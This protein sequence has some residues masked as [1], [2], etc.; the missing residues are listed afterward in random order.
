VLDGE[1]K[2]IEEKEN[3]LGKSMQRGHRTTSSF[4]TIDRPVDD[5]IPLDAFCDMMISVQQSKDLHQKYRSNNRRYPNGVCFSPNVPLCQ[6]IKN[7]MQH[8]AWDW[9]VCIIVVINTLIIIIE[10]D[11]DA[12]LPDGTHETPGLLI[13]ET[14]NMIFGAAYVVELILKVC[15]LGASKYW[16]RLQHRFDIFTTS[17]VVVGQV[18]QIVMKAHNMPMSDV[19][20]YVLLV[21]LT[22]TLRLVVVVRRFNEI[23]AI[24]IDL[25]PAFSTLFGMMWTVFSVYASVG[26]VLFGGKI[27][28]NS[29]KL[30][31]SEFANADYFSNNFNDFASSLVTLFEVSFIPLF[32][33]ILIFF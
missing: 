3:S 24:F 30:A 17:L 25:L 5:L 22:R 18:V 23:F 33:V 6:T 2:T 14:L 16:S 10:A 15:V 19:A 27:T 4:N 29:T 8:Y 32:F 13:C 31:G 26:M 7:A 21:R 1:S 28:T 11:L 9:V 12:G 20:Q